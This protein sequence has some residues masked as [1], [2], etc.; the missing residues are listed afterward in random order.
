[1]VVG[2]VF[3]PESA[4]VDPAA[5]GTRAGEVAGKVPRLAVIAGAGATSAATMLRL[6]F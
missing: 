3:G 1:V 4:A 6:A 2:D 5:V